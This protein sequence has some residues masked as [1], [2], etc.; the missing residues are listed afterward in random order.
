MLSCSLGSAIKKN[1]RW[2]EL[3]RKLQVPA[4]TGLTR[5]QLWRH[6]FVLKHRQNPFKEGKYKGVDFEEVERRWELTKEHFQDYK[7]FTRPFSVNLEATIRGFDIDNMA[8]QQAIQERWQTKKGTYRIK[9][10]VLPDVRDG[11]DVSEGAAASTSDT[12]HYSQDWA[13]DHYMGH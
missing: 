11:R 4:P 2:H 3:A 12:V 5:E 13:G 9:E 1:I 7:E 6:L 10:H 8:A